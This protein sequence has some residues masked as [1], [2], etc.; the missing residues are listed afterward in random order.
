MML[1]RKEKVQSHPTKSTPAWDAQIQKL[2]DVQL[3][4][5]WW[6]LV[7]S[8]AQVGEAELEDIVKIGQAGKNTCWR[9]Q[10]CEQQTAE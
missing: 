7:L 8:M 10:R 1:G 4:G 3:I 5:R 6:K 9:W 2:K